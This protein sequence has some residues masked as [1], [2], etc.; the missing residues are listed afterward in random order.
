IETAR[1][2]STRANCWL[3]APGPK[4]GRG[5]KLRDVRGNG[6]GAGP[7]G[8]FRLVPEAWRRVG[9]LFEPGEDVLA[10][11]VVAPRALLDLQPPLADLGADALGGQQE[12]LPDVGGQ[13]DP[14][15]L[16]HERLE[17]G[18]LSGGVLA[19]WHG[20]L[21]EKGQVHRTL[22]AVSRYSVNPLK[23]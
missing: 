1:S 6:P 5:L 17:R 9:P 19:A 7:S 23:R 22:A 15:G 10:Q 13:V 11:E 12:F 20:I 8:R 2:R 16:D 21:L 4:A 3:V 14:V 18:L